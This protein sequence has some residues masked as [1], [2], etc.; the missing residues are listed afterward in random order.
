LL[1]FIPVILIALSSLIEPPLAGIFIIKKPGRKDPCELELQMLIGGK[2]VCILEKPIVTVGELEYVTDVLYD[3]ALKYHYVDLGISSA[4]VN[5]LNQTIS[6]LPKSEFALVIEGSV[7]CVFTIRERI[8]KR[9]IRLGEDLEFKN[10]VRVRDALKK[11][12]Y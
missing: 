11:V 4:S 6:L 2:Q 9:Y 5:T 7:I 10:I 8:D 1:S 12:K 3:P